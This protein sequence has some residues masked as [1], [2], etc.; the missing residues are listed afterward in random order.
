MSEDINTGGNEDQ[1][2]ENQNSPQGV[3]QEEFNNLTTNVNKLTELIQGMQVSFGEIK[4]SIS[5]PPTVP[6]QPDPAPTLDFSELETLSRGE[7]A[8]KIMDTMMDRL[9]KEVIEPLQGKVGEVE[10]RTEAEKAKALVK[11]AEGKYKDFWDWK[12]EIGERVRAN[13]YL[14]PEEAY[15]L[16]RAANSKKASELDKKYKDNSNEEDES[17]KGKKYGG[18][19]PGAGQ[20]APNENM[21]KRDAAE[22]AW[23]EIFPSS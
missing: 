4:E 1:D 7:F 3:S 9:K 15:H 11:E 14:T 16:S 22:A 12:E 18:M 8:T 10:E 20:T 13:P 17:N 19:K 5:N 6:S 23:E 21:S 2:N